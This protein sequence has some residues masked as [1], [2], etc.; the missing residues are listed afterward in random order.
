VSRVAAALLV[1]PGFPP[2]NVYP[3][4]SE[5]PTVR[6]IVETLSRAIGRPV[7][8]IAI[9]DQQWAD[10]VKARLNPHALDHLSHLWQ[11]FRQA[12]EHYQPTDTIRAVT[13]RNPQ[14]LEEFFRANAEAFA[15]AGR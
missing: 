12:E 7:R 6:E 15:P 5:T 1:N 9:T 8:Y 11:F 2:Q 3:L 10:A 13:G 4:V 14:T